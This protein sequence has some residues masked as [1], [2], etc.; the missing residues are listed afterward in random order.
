MESIEN[1]TLEQEGMAVYEYIVDHAEGEIENMPELIE[2]LKTV[3]VS[4]Q[5]L[6]ST[7]RYLSAIDPGRFALWIPRLIEGAIERDRERRYIGSLLEAI[8]GEDYREHIDELSAADDNFRRIYK[9]L[10]P[11]QGM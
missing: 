9:R 1:N 6:A 7:A 10:H 5:F 2:K 3:D 8:W 4:G 11:G